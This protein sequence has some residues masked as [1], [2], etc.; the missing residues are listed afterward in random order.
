MGSA[1][2]SL[3]AKFAHPDGGV[4]CWRWC[5]ADERINGLITVAH[6]CGN[7]AIRAWS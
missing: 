1:V 5:H 6:Q 7:G 3:A 4:R 2:L